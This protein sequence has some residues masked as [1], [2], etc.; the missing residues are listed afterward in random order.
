[1]TGTRDRVRDVFVAAMRQTYGDAWATDRE[2]LLRFSLDVQ[3]I[4]EG[5]DGAHLLGDPD[6]EQD[7]VRLRLWVDRPV[8]DL[9]T[10]DGLAYVVFGR[11]AEQVFYAER[12][13]E[14]SG[15]LYP[16]VTGTPRRG[17]VGALQLTG[18]HAAEFAE[19]FR[20]RLVGSVRYHA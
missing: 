17:I 20:S 14:T 11:I 18:P 9:M 16:F 12:E 10:A 1:M 13:F 7:E 19:R 15:L 2:A 3:S 8:P 4:L 6:I 5:L